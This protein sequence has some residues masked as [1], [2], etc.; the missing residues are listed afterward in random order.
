MLTPDGKKYRENKYT[1]SFLDISPTILFA[2]GTS[3]TVKTDGVNLASL[4]D[5]MPKIPFKEKLHDRSDLFSKITQDIK[6]D[7]AVLLQ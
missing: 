6:I 4:P 1:A 5:V 2:S 7:K 3:F